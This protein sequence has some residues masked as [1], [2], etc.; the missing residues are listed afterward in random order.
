[1]D[2]ASYS[3]PDREITLDFRPGWGRM[4]S[5]DGPNCRYFS[6]NQFA[7]VRAST[8]ISSSRRSHAGQSLAPSVASRRGR[9]RE[10][11]APGFASIMKH[12]RG[13][14][15]NMGIR[16]SCPNGHKLNVKETLAGRRGICPAC[17]AKFVIP[18]AGDAGPVTGPLAGGASATAQSAAANV[19]AAPSIVIALADAPPAPVPP[20][21]P[22]APASPAVRAAAPGPPET[23][24][25]AAPPIATNDAPLFVADSSHPAAAVSKYTAH[26]MRSRRLQTTIA[27]ALLIAVLVLGIVLVW[28]LSRGTETT[29]LSEHPNRLHVASTCSLSIPMERMNIA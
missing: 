7:G 28:V 5:T 29:R 1:V 23:K 24:S 14:E 20:I 2:D 3:R 18:S 15:R 26:R 9:R 22:T 16:F 6:H 8:P 27:V 19:A 17:G 4:I 13:P 25:P 21:A 10:F 11:F 12:Q